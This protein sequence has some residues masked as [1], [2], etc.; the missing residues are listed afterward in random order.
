MKRLLFILAAVLWASV[1]NAQSPHGVLER[2]KDG[3]RLDGRVLSLQEQGAILSDIGGIDYTS[4]W[5]RYSLWRERGQKCFLSGTIITSIGAGAL[6]GIGAAYLGGMLGV[7][8]IAALA[9]SESEQV[10]DDYDSAFAPWFIGCG[11]IAAAGAATILTGVTILVVNNR[12]MSA[13]CDKYNESS[14]TLQIGL[15]PSGAGLALLF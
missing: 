11:A 14:I 4:E 1:G 9:G 7:I 6:L 2:H 10:F 12:R 8:P 15:T 5:L 3:M 13:I